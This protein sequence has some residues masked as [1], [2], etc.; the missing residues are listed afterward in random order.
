M[1]APLTCALQVDAVTV[2]FGAFQAIT[3]LSLEIKFDEVHAVIGP[4]G[5][6]KTTLLDVI[7]GKTRPKAGRVVL[8]PDIDLLKLSDVD[9]VLSGIGRKFQKPSVFDA[10][11]VAQNLRLALRSKSRTLVAE[12]TYAPTAKD[13]TQ[14]DKILGEIG[15]IEHAGRLAGELAHGQK[16]WLEIGMLLV[17]EPKILLLDE[18][19][20]GMTDEETGHTAA[21]IKRLR[22]PDRAI[23]V[24]EHD[25]S[26]VS[27]IADVVTVLHEGRLLLQGPMATVRA[28]PRVKDVYLG[29]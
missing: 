28:D 13:H 3:D 21:L 15:M 16:Q 11:S 8:E 19:V 27:E 12:I 20:A 7:T 4:N 17:Q 26:F 25:M 6:G 24:I 9:R 23:L 10:L 22:S 14:I 29:R 5:A 18:P 2:S 1:N